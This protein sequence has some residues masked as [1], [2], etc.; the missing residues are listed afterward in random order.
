MH[1]P[2]LTAFSFLLL[3]LAIIPCFYLEIEIT[4]TALMWACL[5]MIPWLILHE[6]LHSLSYVIHGA[7]FKN[8][9]YGVC[10]EKSIL[11]CLCKQNI[12]KKNILYSLLSPFFWLGIVTYILGA[13]LESKLLILLSILNISGSAGDLVMFFFILKLKDVE[14]SEFDNPIAF[15]IYTKESLE[16]KKVLG[17]RW[18]EKKDDLVRNDFKKIHISKPSIWILIGFLFLFGFS[19]FLNC[20]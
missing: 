19:L 2:T 12:S 13:L 3:F 17:L 8:I 1:F 18:M 11:Y 4:Y 16:T 10:L 9:T 5:W 6:V 14:F 7:E 15:G 20:I